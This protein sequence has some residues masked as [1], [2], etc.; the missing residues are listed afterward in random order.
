MARLATAEPVLNAA[1]RWRED[2]LLGAGPILT[3]ESLCTR[4]NAEALQR[5]Y[6]HNLDEGECYFFQKFESQL[7]DAPA[8]AVRLAAEVLWVIY[9]II[10]SRASSG[11]TKRLHIK[12]VFGWSGAEISEDHWAL[13]DVLDQGVAHPGTAY[14]TH[15][16]RELV[17][18]I[19]FLLRWTPLSLEERGRLL[20]DPWAFSEWLD[21]VEGAS[22]RQLPH[23]ICFLL[24]PDSFERI[25]SSRHKERIVEAFSDH[26]GDSVASEYSTRTEL[27]KAVLTVREAMAGEYGQDLDFYKDGLAEAWKPKKRDPPP[28]PL[29]EDAAWVH[30]QFDGHRVWILAAGEGGR[31]WG[32]FRKEGIAA[33][34]WDSLGDLSTYS[35][36]DELA[37]AI[38]KESGNP[39]PKN[40]SLALWE[41]AQIMEPG[42]V[43]IARKGGDHL[44]AHGVV[45][46]PYV[47]DEDR[48]EYQHTRTVDWTPVDNWRC[49]P[50][51][52]PAI[53]TLTDFT[54][55]P[56]WVRDAFGW[57]E[58]NE[59]Q[60]HGEGQIEQSYTLEDALEGLFMT[61]QQL[62]EV[63][64][65][66]A[67]RKNLILEG[68]PG[69]GK[70]FIARRVAWAL[71][72][73]RAKE[74]VEFVQFHQSYAYE[75]FIQGFRPNAD[76]GFE[77]RN[78]VF[79]RFCA[80][81]GASDEPHVFIID[82]IN[83]RNLS[84]SFGELMRLIEADQRGPDHGV[85]LTYSPDGELFYVPD[86]VHVLGMMNT[87]DRSLAMV[88]YALRRRFAFVSLKPA[89]GSETFTQF[90]LDAGVE[91]GVV[92]AIEQ[93][94][95]SL[96][97]SIR[98]DVQNLGPGFEIGHSYFVPS[99]DE[100]SLD[101]HWYRSIVRTQV[102]P[103][104][105]E[106]WFDRPQVLARFSTELELS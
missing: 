92:R 35:N 95:R 48:A 77:L 30:E 75:D 90:L 99:G 42:D 15:R 71:I 83:R 84:R 66:L 3:R 80:K 64:D 29:K 97:Q 69:V 67:Q 72:G 5:H 46:G 103:L 11:A 82:E 60:S 34:G 61:K 89:Y 74:N 73:R 32:D 52:K 53:K 37:A 94:F 106:Y 98:H 19:D 14:Q 55:Y 24:F 41:F 16:W 13:G 43:I 21:G 25:A 51:R 57:L 23:V 65:S 49:P 4:E 36:R 79:Y 33:I 17:F 91:E 85:P 45:T 88:D 20:G 12:N 87:A 86:N 39:N 2:C 101:E 47:F 96:N 105:S 81:A 1:A 54:K 44:V 76:G 56:T 27:D 59:K 18:F 9:L 31:L 62:Q 7:S 26:L 70:T 8:E 104:L 100:T 10:S 22:K 68:P 38:T 50:D 28:T 63:L 40:D 58:G 6:S 93:R 78:G 102:L